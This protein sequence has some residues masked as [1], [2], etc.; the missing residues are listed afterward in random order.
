MSAAADERPANIRWLP[1][2]LRPPGGMTVRAE[3]VFLLVGL[4][5]LF[6]GYDMGV[7]GFAVP[8]IQV[9]LHIPEDQVGITI[10]YFRLAALAAV[11]LA[12]SADLVGRRRLLLF[13]IVG[14]AVATLYTAFAQDYAQFVWAQIVTRV[15][16]YAEE[17]L[18][19]VVI[20]E[21]VAAEFARLGEWHAGGN[22]LYGRRACV[23]REWVDQHPSRRLARAVCDRFAAA[24]PGGLFASPLARNQALRGAR[25]KRCRNFLRASAR[26]WI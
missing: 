9:S 8:K 13:T 26:H 12:W 16:G 15:F 5:A 24:V 17:M 18:C 7:F 21:E 19:Y 1:P 6:A 4:A 14:Q 22:E 2:G 20:A 3:R 25:T 11:I 23:G 10:S